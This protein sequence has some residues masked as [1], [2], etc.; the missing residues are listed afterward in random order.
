MMKKRYSRLVSAFLVFILIFDLFGSSAGGGADIAGMLRAYAAR[1]DYSVSFHWTTEGLDGETDK[2]D[3]TLNSSEDVME[4]KEKVNE[5]VNLKAVFNLNLEKRIDAGNISF[6]ITGLNALVR[7]GMLPLNVLDPS[8]IETWEIVPDYAN[9]TYTFTNRV[10]V[11]SDNETTFTWSFESR[12]A[13]NGSDITLGT[14]V[15][16]KEFD[17]NDNP[18]PDI[19][20]DTGDLRLKY[21]SVHDD[22]QVKIVC[23]DPDETDFNNLNGHYDWRSYYSV[24]GLKGIKEYDKQA[25]G[26]TEYVGANQETDAHWAQQDDATQRGSVKS[27]GISS[28]DYFIQIDSDFAENE[29]L[30]VDLSGN[31]V[32]LDTY[33]VDG[34]Q[35][36]GFYAFRNKGDIKPG[37]SYTCEYRVGV[38]NDA[39]E[40]NKKGVTLT[41]HYL[42]T[43]NDESK[44]YDHTDTASHSVD[45]D[46]PQ[47]IGEGGG[48]IRKTNTYEIN[49]RHYY[50]GHWYN[51]HAKHYNGVYQLLYD[52]IF[53]GAVVTYYLSASSPEIE[54]E[55]NST[56]TQ[57]AYKQYDLIYTDGA[58][59]LVN[60]DNGQTRALRAEEYDFRRILVKKLIKGDTVDN[61]DNS[62]GFNYDIYT[63]HENDD[64]VLFRTDSS[65]QDHTGITTTETEYFFGPGVDQIKLVV[66]DLDIRAEIDANVDIEYKVDDA[67]RG[68]ISIKPTNVPNGATITEDSNEGTRLKNT[69]TRVQYVKTD[70]SDN[71]D[72]SDDSYVGDK[73][74]HKND[75]HSNTWL[76]SSVTFIES[77]TYMDPISYDNTEKR[78][79]TNIKSVGKL[80]SDTQKKLD[81]FVMYTK[82]PDDMHLDSD[83]LEKF[84]DSLE[85]SGTLLGGQ[86]VDADYVRD[87]DLVSAY[88]DPATKCVVTRFDFTGGSLDASAM[89][90]VGY[91]IPSGITLAQFNALGTSKRFTAET[92]LAVLDQGMRVSAVEKKGLVDGGN[93]PTQKDASKSE[94]HQDIYALGS[95]KSNYAAK[96][97]K[98]SYNEW[99]Y[100]TSAEVDGSNADHLDSDVSP[101]RMTSE[102]S[103]QLVFNR[104]STVTTDKLVNPVMVDVIEGLQ[105]SAW[106]GRVNAVRI[107]PNI[108]YS[109]DYTPEVYYKLRT[110]LND[111][112]QQPNNDNAYKLEYDAVD[113]AV[114]CFRDYGS[115]DD[116]NDQKTALYDALKTDIEGWTKVDGSDGVYRIDQDNVY[117]V[118]VIFR[119]EHTI[120]SSQQVK[121]TAEIDLKAPAVSNDT[122]DSEKANNNRATWNDFH[123]F[124]M[125]HTSGTG[126]NV[127]IYSVS[128][129]TMVILRHNVELMKVSS[130]DPT[131]RL[132]GAQFSVYNGNPTGA[133]DSDNNIVEYYERGAGSSADMQRMENKEV[134]MSGVLQ[135]NLAPGIYYYKETKAPK[136]YDLDTRIYRFRAISDAH[137]VYSY[138]TELITGTPA[139]SGHLIANDTEYEAYKTSVYQ[140]KT[141]DTD[142]GFRLYRDGSTQAYDKLTESANGEYTYDE[143]SGT[144]E[145]LKCDNDGKITF[146][147]LPAGTYFLGTSPTDKDG[148]SFSV[149]DGSSITFRIFKRSAMTSGMGYKLYRM[150]GNT[151]SADDIPCDLSGDAGSYGLSGDASDGSGTPLTTDGNGMISISGLDSGE[152]YYLVNTAAPHGYTLTDIKEIDGS[153]TPAVFYAAETLKATDKLVAKDEPIKIANAMFRKIDGTAFREN[154][155][156]TGLNEAVYR[157]Y[158]VEDDGTESL[159]Y[160]SYN[161]TSK[162]Y[163]YVGKSGSADYVSTLE[164]RNVEDQDGMIIVKHLNYG[165]YALEELT[166]PKGYQ[167]SSSKTYFRVMASTIDPEGNVLFADETSA[168]VG[169]T[170]KTLRLG[171]EEVLSKLI[172]RKANASADEHYLKNAKYDLFRLRKNTNTEV[173]DEDYLDA[174]KNASINSMKL[175]GD[176]TTFSNYWKL[177]GTYT[178]N[179][180]GEIT[181]DS[182]PF[183]TYLFYENMPPTGYKWN[184]DL[185][186]WKTWGYKTADNKTTSQIILIDKE[187]VSANS[188]K[189]SVLVKDESGNAPGSADYTETYADGAT[190]FPFYSEH[191][192]E[193]KTGEAKLVKTNDSNIGLNDAIF[194]L[195]K[196]EPT[197]E[198]IKNIL[199]A[200]LDA[201]ELAKVNMNSA[202]DK[203]KALNKVELNLSD[204][205]DDDSALIDIN[206]HYTYDLVANTYRPVTD[207]GGTPIDTAVSTSMKTNADGKGGTIVKKGLEWGLY[208]FCEVKAPTGYR[209]DKTAK[210]FAVNSSTVGNTIELKVT[211][212][213]TYGKIWLYK[214]AKDKIDGTDNDHEKLF[215]AHF[216]LFTKENAPVYAIPRLRLNDGS[217]TEHLVSKIEV[218]TPDDPLTTEIEITYYDGHDDHVVRAVYEKTD[219]GNIKKLYIDNVE[220]TA[221]DD[222]GKFR[223]TYYAVSADGEKYYDDTKGKYVDITPDIK[224]YRTNDYITVDKGGQLSVRGLDWGAYYFRET[225]PPEGYGLAEDVI[226]TVNAFNCEN[227]FLACEDPKAKAAVIVDKE[228]P[229]ADLEYFKA[230]GEP[231][232][233]FKVWEL[234]ET[235]TASEVVYTHD[236]KDYKKTGRSYTLAIPLT[237]GHNKGSAMVNVDRGKYLIEEL[238]V[239]R[240]ECKDLT[241]IASASPTVDNDTFTSAGLDTP[242]SYVVYD[243]NYK[244]DNDPNNA[245]K[246]TAFCNLD[247]GVSTELPVFHVKYENRIKKYDRFS[248]VS[249]ADNVIPGRKYVTAFKPMYG[250]LIETKEGTPDENDPTIT[251]AIYQLD[252]TIEDD[253]PFSG[254]LSYNVEGQ[255]RDLTD[256]DLD[257]LAFNVPSE[258]RDKIVCSHDGSKLTLTVTDPT[259]FAGQTVQL[260]VGYF[261]DGTVNPAYNE[262]NTSMVK[263]TLDLTF[264]ELKTAN[265]KKLLLKNDVGNRS[266]FTETVT[267]TTGEGTTTRQDPISSVSV[268]YTL[269]KQY[270]TV[271][272]NEEGLSNITKEDMS[273]KNQSDKLKVDKGYMFQYWYLV[274]ENTG[275]PVSGSDGK[276]LQFKHDIADVTKSDIVKYMYYGTR[277]DGTTD[278]VTNISSFTFQAMLEKGTPLTA[279]VILNTNDMLDTNGILGSGN[280]GRVTD[281]P[282]TNGS[283]ITGVKKGTMTA[284]KEGNEEGWNSCADNHRLTY[285]SYKSTGYNAGDPYPDLVRFYEIGTEVYWYTVDRDTLE[286]TNGSVYV[287]YTS[288]YYENYPKL[289]S[290]YSKLTDVS[291]IFDWELSGM[292]MLGK[293][294]E[295]T[296]ITTFTLNRPY[297]KTG[298]MYMNRMF[299]NCKNLTSVTMT[300]DTSGA[301]DGKADAGGGSTPLSAQTKEM[302]NGCSSLTTLNLSGDFTKLY[303]DQSMFNSCSLLPAAEFERAFSTWQ[304][305][306][307]HTMQNNNIFGGYNNKGS[308]NNLVDANGVHFKRNGDTIVANN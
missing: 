293:M 96:S 265:V 246:W 299:L 29:L 83:W 43:Y 238:P 166:A 7:S 233:M 292:D 100:D 37:E 308:I 290:G 200:K 21:E 127:P 181:V 56:V 64:W 149:A 80:H 260:E 120:G 125:N 258:Y 228:I 180:S 271:P 157:M 5:P 112:A 215:G 131:K 255:E 267:V 148:Y 248:E 243:G 6:T 150:I 156:E 92:Y 66:R 31:R 266:H 30:V 1:E 237:A 140:G 207:S 147:D 123:T 275:L 103:Y 254:V 244:L 295:S 111:A 168:T 45:K 84:R 182:L 226:F 97:V 88:Y 57:K 167:L 217:S 196:I 33:T 306:T 206:R 270:N 143:T 213:K 210:L 175:T 95:Q 34:K 60:L 276:P 58:P 118:A 257:H 197:D 106:H 282:D 75:A 67:D 27:R 261:Q 152:K 102:Y 11:V 203:R 47:N 117:A 280:A 159:M 221:E 160:F 163:T 236:S 55:G 177:V 305:D 241:L 302:F 232:F 105:R 72:V 235:D 23:K 231:T 289:F 115:A 73:Y 98:S 178:T 137:K 10:P 239:S 291:G 173:T 109:E 32:P 172:F 272:L 136:G 124:A 9:D 51:E 273:A 126:D 108:N 296:A 284:F 128:D 36:F 8:I 81:Q 223:L 93:N 94:A 185:S 251:K 54:D 220:Q 155:S 189:T 46:D 69:F 227:Q 70:N 174:A 63:K 12:N 116:Q 274:D 139:A 129:K 22:N 35:L 222:I 142:S 201:K 234:E 240:Y 204:I 62:T 134:N 53:D 190:Y 187:T 119:G 17:E 68:N 285:D 78:Y 39:I 176:G 20:I 179:G 59:Q 25:E 250:E 256:V 259:A 15:T 49:H 133:I 162:E 130:E 279:R 40:E 79:S 28:S 165:T 211:D 170:T 214:Q 202:A 4:L 61:R 52:K 219:K 77:A 41:G 114:D 135:M 300:V 14:S 146:S 158:A 252:L 224:R 183:G 161:N 87:N 154:K 253:K 3:C 82:V 48:W 286:P 307:S 44:V 113:D 85:F 205:G 262:D 242:T 269:P 145:E 138:T 164:S 192:D 263:G 89:T 199:R 65:P 194:A 153:Q 209:A 107:D 245:P 110:G 141:F 193:R 184:N 225:I 264:G 171:D 26:R 208:Y 13:V 188:D 91:T 122:S 18:M 38:L 132:T 195:Y 229:V 304:W 249:F 281:N 218:V 278:D 86:T 301:G 24:V 74:E 90:E 16:I 71:Y 76:R 2:R 151:R 297:K 42:V 288:T 121:L 247:V 19:V 144:Q 268:Q 283:G 191:S 212:D 104:F 169:A 99:V 230:Y 294:F 101:T 50:N 277:P 216:G 198:E 186:A 287:E 303:N 298:M